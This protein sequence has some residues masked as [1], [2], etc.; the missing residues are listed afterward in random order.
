MFKKSY[1]VC[2]AKNNIENTVLKSIWRQN[3]THGICSVKQD[4]YL[5]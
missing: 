1:Q 5:F 3:D 2:M 4:L